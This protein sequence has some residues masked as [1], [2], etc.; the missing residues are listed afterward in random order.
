MISRPRYVAAEPPGRAGTGTGPDGDVFEASYDTATDDAQTT[1]YTHTTITDVKPGW[2]D[3]LVGAEDNVETTTTTT[4]TTTQT[5]D[6]RSDDKVTTTITLF[7]QGN[8]DPYDVKIFYDRTFGTYLIIDADSP[9]LKGVG[10]SKEVPAL[11]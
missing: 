7:S 9:L 2:I 4:L 1:T 5:T 6:N 11:A 10:V 8:N 3:V